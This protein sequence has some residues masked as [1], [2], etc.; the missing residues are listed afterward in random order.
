MRKTLLFLAL[1]YALVSACTGKKQNAAYYESRIDSLNRMTMRGVVDTNTVTEVSNGVYA[2]AD[3][4]PSDTAGA[5]LMFNLA[6][7][8]QGNKMYDRSIRTLRE[9]RQRYPS[10]PYAS[11][12]LV[13]E[14]FINANVTRKYDDARKAYTEY[15]EKYRSV[16]TGLSRDV[17]M[18]LQTMGKTPEQLMQEFQ[19]RQHQDSL[20]RLPQ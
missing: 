14:G 10:S 7:A 20:E 18:E 17:E 9:L 13:L 6:R 1:A 12:A 15:L 3:K 2:Y 19:A 11:K 16:D 4:N 8:E 5:R